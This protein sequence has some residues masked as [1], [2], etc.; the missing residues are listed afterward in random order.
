MDNPTHTPREIQVR[1]IEHFLRTLFEPGDIIEI[2]GLGSPKYGTMRIL[3]RDFNR[4]ARA[5]V[6][7]SAEGAD[8]Y[9][10][11]NPV[12]A[13]S[14]YARAVKLDNLPRRAS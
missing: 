11:L 14:Q 7:M 5:A 8:T 4:A 12:A 6:K 10:G 2:R 1:N 9:F 13:D 3:T